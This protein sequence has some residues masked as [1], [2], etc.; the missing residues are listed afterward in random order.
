MKNKECNVCKKKFLRILDLGLHPCADIFV[1][2]Q[3]IAL[4]L[5]KYLDEIPPNFW[6][7]K[8]SLSKQIF[9]LNLLIE[10]ILFYF[11]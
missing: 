7:Q 10:P 3:K 2:K 9:T 8:I 4:K 11:L 1:K 5:K 6:I